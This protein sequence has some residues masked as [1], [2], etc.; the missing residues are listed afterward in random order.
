MELI[1]SG[2]FGIS[3]TCYLEISAEVLTI[4]LV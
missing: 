1:D 3:E 2:K 4:T